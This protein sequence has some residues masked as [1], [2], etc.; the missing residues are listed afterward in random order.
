LFWTATVDHVLSR[1]TPALFPA[2]LG[3]L[4]FASGLALRH[5]SI[6]RLGER[7]LDDVCLLPGHR[8]ETEGLY[9][10]L[11][12]PSEA[13]S[14]AWGRGPRSCSRA[15]PPAS[16]GSRRWHRSRSTASVS[17]TACW[18]GISGPSTWPTPAGSAVS[19]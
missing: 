7:F 3:G 15:P 1:R 14:C 11:R 13:D 9:G 17:R 19:F 12:H 16:C 6:R 2:V 18:P 8:L 10:V 4:V 5:A